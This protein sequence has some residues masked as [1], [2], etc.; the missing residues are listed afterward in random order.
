LW[1]LV[2][3]VVHAEGQ[4]DCGDTGLE[5]N[6][7]CYHLILNS[8]A[9]VDAEEYCTRAFGGHLTSVHNAFETSFLFRKYKLRVNEKRFCTTTNVLALAIGSVIPIHT[10]SLY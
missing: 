2:I 3:F 1:L 6:G 5:F 4:A 8:R 9:F 7:N 10:L